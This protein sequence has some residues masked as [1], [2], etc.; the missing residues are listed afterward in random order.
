MSPA[1]DNGIFRI[2]SNHSFDETVARLQSM[3]Q[4]KE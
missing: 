4:P 2:P 1:P 3:L